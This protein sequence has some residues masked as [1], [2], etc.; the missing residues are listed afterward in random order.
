MWKRISSYFCN[1]TNLQQ[2]LMLLPTTI[3][4]KIPS[5]VSYFDSTTMLYQLLAV[6]PTTIVVRIPFYFLMV[7]LLK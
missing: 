4:V 5:M 6:M 2:L 3:V 7:W 1:T